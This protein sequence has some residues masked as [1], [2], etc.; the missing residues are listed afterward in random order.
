MDGAITLA[1][2]DGSNDV[3]MLQ[4]ANLGKHDK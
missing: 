2:G 3:E 4:K 1:I